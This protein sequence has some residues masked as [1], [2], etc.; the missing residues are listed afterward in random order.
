MLVVWGRRVGLRGARVV[1]GLARAKRLQH[2]AEVLEPEGRL[3]LVLGAKALF[4][5]VLRSERSGTVSTPEILMFSDASDGIEA[6]TR[7]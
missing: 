5:A 1:R 6:W 2:Q 4:R 3:L 7:G